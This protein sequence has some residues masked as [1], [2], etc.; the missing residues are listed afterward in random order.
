MAACQS[1]R[2]ANG[3]VPIWRSGFLAIRRLLS[4]GPV[5]PWLFLDSGMACGSVRAF[6]T[7]SDTPVCET[8]AG[9]PF[10]SQTRAFAKTSNLRTS[11]DAA[12]CAPARRDRLPKHRG[13]RLSPVV[14]VHHAVTLAH[15]TALAFNAAA[16]VAF[17]AVSPIGIR[18]PASNTSGTPPLT[19]H[20]L[21]TRRI[22][23]GN[24]VDMSAA[25]LTH[26]DWYPRA[27]VLLYP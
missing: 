25:L 8:R 13:G 14:A 1:G 22:D 21:I 20:G 5:L 10:M 23:C 15:F 12:A 9:G 11:I 16:S 27:L 18:Q 19:A 2:M 3:G 7:C 26:A 4:Q 24:R 6:P 17:G